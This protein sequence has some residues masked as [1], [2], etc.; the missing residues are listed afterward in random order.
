MHLA[1]PDLISLH[2]RGLVRAQ[3]PDR[4]RPSGVRTTWRAKAPFFKSTRLASFPLREQVGAQ[5]TAMIIGI[6]YLDTWR[7]SHR[8]TSAAVEPPHAL[9]LT[10]VTSRA[11]TLRAPPC[12]CQPSCTSG[13]RAPGPAH[14]IALK[15]PDVWVRDMTGRLLS[16]GQSIRR[17]RE[18]VPLTDVF[19]VRA[20]HVLAIDS[21]SPYRAEP[22][23]CATPGSTLPVC[24][25]RYGG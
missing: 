12:Y 17:D 9:R 19:V 24:R 21:I 10:H 18:V 6:R 4:G 2:M 7:A 14:P 5:Q 8:G 16:N 23:R 15:F 22:D 11:R 1:A 20:V 25:R 3:D 13:S